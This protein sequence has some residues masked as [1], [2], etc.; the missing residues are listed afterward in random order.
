MSTLHGIE[1]ETF[2][3]LFRRGRETTAINILVLHNFFG[4]GH[5][6]HGVDFGFGTR[7]RSWTNSI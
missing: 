7:S 2:G 4:D 6:S 1:E 3:R 5:L